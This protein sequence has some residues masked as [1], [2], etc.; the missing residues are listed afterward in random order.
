MLE[1]SLPFPPPHTP[2]YNKFHL[3]T[4][5][6][7][8]SS[9]DSF[10]F[11]KVPL[12]SCEKLSKTTNYNTWACA[13]KLWFHSQSLEDHLTKQAKILPRFITQNEKKMMYPYA[14]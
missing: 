13:V 2:L 7:D 12:T 10:T 5:M 1:S 8:N 11:T 3:P 4:L 14:T 9:I 6:G